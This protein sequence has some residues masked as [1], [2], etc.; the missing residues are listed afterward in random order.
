[1]ILRFK[2]IYIYIH[3]ISIYNPYNSHRNAIEIA[4]RTLVRL[5]SVVASTKDSG[6]QQ[7]V[8]KWRGVESVVDAYNDI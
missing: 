4:A 5:I 7:G 6:S 3:I 2:S 8:V 1:M